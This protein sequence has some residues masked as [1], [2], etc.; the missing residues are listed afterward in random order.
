MT[1]HEPLF[2]TITVNDVKALVTEKTKLVT[3]GKTLP[4]LHHICYLHFYVGM[5][6]SEQTHGMLNSERRTSKKLAEQGT[7]ELSIAMT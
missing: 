4:F 7:L 3:S 5:R 1:E 2:C 6:K